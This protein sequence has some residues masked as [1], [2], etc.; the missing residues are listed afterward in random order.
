M[1]PQAGRTERSTEVIS[2][3]EKATAGYSKPIFFRLRSVFLSHAIHT[4]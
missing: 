1:S 2:L 3:S 4:S